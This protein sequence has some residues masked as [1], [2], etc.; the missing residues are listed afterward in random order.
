MSTHAVVWSSE[1]NRCAGR[2]ESFAD[3]FELVGRD[4]R[5]TLQFSDLT[6]VSI[7]RDRADRLLGMPV[8]TLQ[9]CAGDRVRIAA[10][11]GPGL[12]HDLAARIEHGRRAQP[13]SYRA[14]TGR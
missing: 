10:L 4:R 3:R 11:E 7:A 14:E 2:L 12:L 5:L 6:D 9:R 8:L 1:G 13:E